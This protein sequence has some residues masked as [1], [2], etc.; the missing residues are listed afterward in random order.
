MRQS[1][2]SGASVFFGNDAL[3][4]GMLGQKAVANAEI[5]VYA[6]EKHAER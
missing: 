6:K 5:I 1:S 2:E 4:W 3:K